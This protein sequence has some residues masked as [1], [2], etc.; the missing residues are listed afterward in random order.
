M[1]KSLQGFGGLCSWPTDRGVLKLWMQG[2]ASLECRKVACG[3]RDIPWSGPPCWR[4]S[5][6]G[7]GQRWV[8]QLRPQPA[9]P[10]S[11]V[12]ARPPCLFPTTALCAGSQ[13]MQS[14]RDSGSARLHTS[15]RA[16]VRE[17]GPDSSSLEHQSGANARLT[18]LDQ[19]ILCQPCCTR[20]D[21]YGAPEITHTSRL[22]MCQAEEYL[23]ADGLVE[24]DSI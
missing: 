1:S 13:S 2:S 3:V 9:H 4:S 20:Q 14:I 21:V 8:P 22:C 11:T 7:D 12:R 6:A 18:A 5:A 17:E 24:Q 23:M 15:C 16:H 10:S 19:D